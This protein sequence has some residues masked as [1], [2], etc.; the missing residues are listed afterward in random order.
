[1]RAWELQDFGLENLRLVDRPEPVPGPGQIAVRVRAAAL[2][3]RDLQVIADKYDPEQRLPIVPVSDGVGEVIAVGAGV[4]RIRLG[5]RVIGAFAQKWIAGERT[6]D[7]WA[8]HLG[9]HRDGMLQDIVLLDAEGAVRVPAY[10][11]DLQAAAAGAAWATAWQALF[12]QGGLQPGQTVLAQGTGGVSVAALQLASAAGARVIVTSGSDAKLARARA[13][14][15]AVG[16]NYRERPDWEAAVLDATGGEGVDH[17]IDNVGD[18][19]RTVAC[20]KVGGLVSLVGYL[21]Q[22]RLVLDQAPPAYR[23][24]VP[25]LP[26]LLRNVRLQ[27]L[28]VGPRESYDAMMRA[29][30]ANRIVPAVDERVFAFEAAPEALRYLA[31]GAHFG[32]ICIAVG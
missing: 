30:E 28:S 14:G 6:W 31:S 27:G 20:V 8:S 7:R 25:I 29:I 10:L 2:N 4:D 22:L 5:E 9:G 11:T 26:V 17:V 23:Y 21:G 16:I 19:E 13:L 15:A 32:K 3:S 1:M 18:L 12:G 24:D